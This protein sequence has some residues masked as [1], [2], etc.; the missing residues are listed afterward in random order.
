MSEAVAA[1]RIA[2]LEAELKAERQRRQEVEWKLRQLLAKYFAK[3]SEKVDPLQ[4]Q[5]ALE[6]MQAIAAEKA[7][8]EIE[9][10][11]E[12]R[13]RTKSSSSK[14]S[15]FPEEM[16]EEI[17][18]VDLPQ[19]E[20]ICPETGKERKFIRW[21]ETTK[22][23][24][25]PAQFVRV[26]IRRAVRA[27][28]LA[29]SDPLPEQRVVTAEMPAA[30]RV[31][32]GSMAASGLLVF[33][34]IA[35]Y[36]DHLPLY[37]LQQIFK[38]RHRV[39][40]D[41]ATMCH[42]MKRC[43]AILG[44]LYEALRQQLISQNYL[45]ID[46]TFVRLLDPEVKGKAK[47]ANFWVLKRPGVGVL[48]HFDKSRSHDV[49]AELLSGF[50]GKLQCD[51]YG[52]YDV[53]ERKSDAILLFRCWAH[54]RRKFHEALEANGA[55]ALWYIAEVQRLYRIESEARKAGLN[56]FERGALRAAESKPVLDAIRAR[57]ERDLAST[58]ILPSSPLGK[59]VRY[60]IAY[61]PGLTRYAE[62]E[63]GDV[64]I[65]NNETENAIRPTAV[66]KKNWLFIGH[67]NA[68]QMSAIIYTIVENCR[69]HGIDPM[70]YLLDVLPRI[71]DHPKS[72]IGDLLP[73]AWKQARE[74][75]NAA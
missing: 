51:G 39:E 30:Y 24:F 74:S 23:N 1:T 37:R 10:S 32:P 42:W 59:A 27:V 7:S 35:K 20:R 4:L 41:R 56:P 73:L 58:E 31:I 14:R 49:A 25:V 57:L 75:Q 54:T 12:Q 71:E 67:P 48:F 45:Q 43:A 46:E 34:M 44:V 55:K 6:G 33:L 19:E 61:W 38:S 29:E 69:L 65:D 28:T 22:I 18:E 17:I 60:A 36:C 50:S 15:S 47:Q 68:G 62:A 8:E 66:G 26:I 9:A 40:I 3:S 63:H 52:G 53:L 72:K 13:N 5:L 2:Q 16:R 64:E 11:V 70:E 21:E